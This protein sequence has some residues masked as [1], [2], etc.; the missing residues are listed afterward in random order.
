[1]KQRKPTSRRT[2]ARGLR[3]WV[4]L[5]WTALTNGYLKGYA[6]G[7]IYTGKSKL[8]CVPGLNCYSCPGALGSCPIGALQATL[9]SRHYKFTFYVLGFLLVTGAAL[10]RFVCGWL[11]P[12][13]LVQDLLWRIPVFQSWRK[14]HK[15]LPGEKLLRALRWAVL[16]VLCI[17]LPLIAVD[18]VGNGKPW[19]CAYLCPAGTLGAGIPLMLLNESLRS[20][21]GW[22]F[23]WKALV[24]GILLFASLLLWRPFCRYLCPLGAVYGCFN[25]TALARYEVDPAA[26]T[27]CGACKAACPLDIPVW[28]TP[29]SMDCVR[30]GKCKAIC[31]EKAIHWHRPFS[32]VGADRS[33][34]EPSV[35]SLSDDRKENDCE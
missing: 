20:A 18:V 9:G 13:G 1:M 10:G 30:C 3:Q 34:A 32:A 24:L 27:G 21:A 12:V 14:K 16:G 26:C 22:L 4:Q 5:V 35:Q 11:C 31:P 7:R 29:N 17:L 25:R 15:C 8:L 33:S 2:P 28:Q 6:E 23:S 19:F